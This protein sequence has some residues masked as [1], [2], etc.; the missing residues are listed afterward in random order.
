MDMIFGVND[1]CQWYW[2]SVGLK[3]VCGIVLFLSLVTGRALFRSCHSKEV[4]RCVLRPEPGLHL[5]GEPRTQN[6]TAETQLT[7]Q[8]WVITRYSSVFGTDFGVICFEPYDGGI[9][10]SVWFWPS[11]TLWG[12][13]QQHSSSCLPALLWGPPEER[14]H[15]ANSQKLYNANGITN[16]P[17][18]T[19]IF[20][21]YSVF[22]W[23]SKCWKLY[24]NCQITSTVLCV[25]LK[26]QGQKRENPTFILPLVQS[27]SREFLTVVWN[28][29][30]GWLTVQS[31]GLWGVPLL[32]WGHS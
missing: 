18:S 6:K 32:P 10:C 23:I 21:H 22:L 1:G 16:Q 20:S 25:A 19:S 27:L 31:L 11:A 2:H 14:R 5:G 3:W 7:T 4:A 13:P 9:D 29:C 26:S 17:T 8:A 30:S 24:T 12:F 28:Y 15:L